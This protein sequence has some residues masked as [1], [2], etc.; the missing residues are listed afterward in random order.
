MREGKEYCFDEN[1][2]PLAGQALYDLCRQEYGDTIL[3]GF[4]QGKDSIAMWLELRE[5]F[6]I[7]PFF[8]YH[9]PGLEFIEASLDYY[10]RFF[11]THIIRLPHHLLYKTLNDFMYQP[12]H[13]VA[14]IRA[15]SMPPYDYPEL[16]QII[17]DS[18]GIPMTAVALG[19]RALDNIDRRY[20]IHR[21]GALGKLPNKPYFFAVWDWSVGRISDIIIKNKVKLPV[22]YQIMGRT[23]ISW[24]YQYIKPIK[25]NF[26]RDWERMLEWWPWL[27]LELFRY[28]KV[29][30]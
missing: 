15:I 17:C 16:G 3:L 24:E 25:D 2:Q 8:M 21:E 20:L 13:R 4:S 5:H 7:I 26:P 22:S 27:D 29:G 9:C 28:E 11:G 1:G 23:I 19:H 10:E 14:T 12:P 6:N 30:Q 18:K